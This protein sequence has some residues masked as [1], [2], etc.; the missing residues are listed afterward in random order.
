MNCRDCTYW[1]EYVS[2]WGE[3]SG[4]GECN[5]KKGALNKPTTI[6]KGKMIIAING[7]VFTET[8]YGCEEGEK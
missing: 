4:V 8:M 6:M 3:S 7:D 5:N 1:S 2:K